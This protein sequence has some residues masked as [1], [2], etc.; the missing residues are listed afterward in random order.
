V[1]ILLDN[2]PGYPDNL[3]RGL[4]GKLWLGLAGQRNA[5]DA[6]AQ[7]PALRKMV[8]RVP[9]LFWAPPK[10]Y[11]HVFAFSEDGKVLADLQDPGG[12][13]PATTGVTETA[14][15]LYIHNVDGKSLGWLGPQARQSR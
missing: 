2:L 5:L 12:A 4:D 11:G 14:G 3:T 9:R 7:H 8:L 6:M 1:R 10:P 15:R 13:S